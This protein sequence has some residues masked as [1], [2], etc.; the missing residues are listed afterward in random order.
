[1]GYSQVQKEMITENGCGTL[2]DPGEGFVDRLAETVVQWHG[3][4]EQRIEM[5]KKASDLSRTRYNYDSVAEE[6]EKLY[7]YYSII[8]D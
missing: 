2:I 3:N 7:T 5:G 6:F 8:L 1:M 4:P